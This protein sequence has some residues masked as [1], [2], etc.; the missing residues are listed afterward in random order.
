MLACS[1][2]LMASCPSRLAGPGGRHLASAQTFGG[3]AATKENLDCLRRDRNNEEEEDAP[4]IVTFY[5][6][7][8]RETGSFTSWDKSG[9][10]QDSGE[11][12]DRQARVIRNI[13]EFSASTVWPSSS[14]IPPSPSTPPAACPPRPI[15]DEGLRRELR[16]VGSGRQ[17]KLLPAG[18]MAQG[19]RFG[20]LGHIQ[21]KGHG[22]RGR[23]RRDLPRR[24]RS[25]VSAPGLGSITSQ[26]YQRVQI[27][28]IGSCSP[29]RSAR[30]S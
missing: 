30:T 22:V 8:S 14:S 11:L 19:L 27:N 4:E 9:S 2:R 15:R 23:R 18:A 29:R 28:C 16:P 1:R 20:K 24:R 12:C 17:R 6:S 26:N 25:H 3:S 7:N 21:E 5:G 13:Q 10:M